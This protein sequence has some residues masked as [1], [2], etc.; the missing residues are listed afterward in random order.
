MR[1]KNAS[2]L[3]KIWGERT[4]ENM[5]GIVTKLIFQNIVVKDDLGISKVMK[6]SLPNLNDTDFRS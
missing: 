3:C 4:P 1:G 6:I 5:D 2:N